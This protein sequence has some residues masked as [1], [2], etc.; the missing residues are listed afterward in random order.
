M[1]PAQDALTEASAQGLHLATA[2]NLGR[3]IALVRAQ[4]AAAAGGAAGCDAAT[5]PSDVLQLL[6]AQGAWAVSSY[7]ACQTLKLSAAYIWPLCCCAYAG[8]A[9][10]SSSMLYG[11]AAPLEQGCAAYRSGLIAE[12]FCQRRVNSSLEAGQSSV[13]D[14]QPMA[15]PEVSD[16]GTH[17]V[18]RPL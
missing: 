7:T 1:V 12:L 4:A 9:T 10:Y 15:T 17:P 11:Q 2:A 18:R 6:L 5:R 3:E 13:L 8:G 14:S 16:T